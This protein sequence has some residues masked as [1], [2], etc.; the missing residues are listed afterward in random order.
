MTSGQWRG[1]T[2]AS[3][4]CKGQP[5]GLDRTNQSRCGNRPHAPP[6]SSAISAPRPVAFAGL[7]CNYRPPF[8]PFPQRPTPSLR[9]GCFPRQPLHPPRVH[10]SSID[11]PSRSWIRSVRLFPSWPPPGEAEPKAPQRPHVTT[12]PRRRLCFASE[13]FRPRSNILRVHT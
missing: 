5:P 1:L 13:R 3:H 4:R 2:E 6:N 7:F 12:P 11:R 10:H 8:S 9:P